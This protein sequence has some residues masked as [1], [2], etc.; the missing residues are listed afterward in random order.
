MTLARNLG[1]LALALCLPGIAAQSTDP[2]TPPQ[3]QPAAQPESPQTKPQAEPAVPPAPDS[4]QTPQLPPESNPQEAAPAQPQVTQPSTPPTASEE[5]A[6][7]KKRRKKKVKTTPAIPTDGPTKTVVRNGS[8]AEPQVK[9]T[10]GT[11]SGQENR[12]RGKVNYLLTSTDDNLKK[13]ST[14]QLNPAQ[15]DAVTQIRAYMEQAK[16]ALDAGYLQR[17]ENLAAKARLLS[18][19]LLKQ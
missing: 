5:P 14:R 2:S 18:D 7:K 19:D 11:S 17:G 13:I 9:F 15:Q 3:D 12:Q 4:Q 1:I 10:P 8:T 6:K 16:E